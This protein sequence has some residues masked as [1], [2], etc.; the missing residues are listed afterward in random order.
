MVLMRSLQVCRTPVVNQLLSSTCALHTSGTP[1]HVIITTMRLGLFTFFLLLFILPHCYLA[2]RQR[3]KSSH[4]LTPS[5][6]AAAVMY[7]MLQGRPMP[8][9]R[10]FCKHH[11]LNLPWHHAC[12][13][14]TKQA[15]AVEQHTACLAG[16]RTVLL[17]PAQFKSAEHMQPAQFFTTC[18]Q[19]Y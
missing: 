19:Q 9:R 7:C 12:C 4:K 2:F 10:L 17:L 5:L 15:F 1:L 18:Q 3:F 6:Q 13:S 11:H 8:C 16:G 14:I